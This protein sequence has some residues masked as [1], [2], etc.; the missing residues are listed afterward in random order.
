MRE[1]DFLMF[2][3][4]GIGEDLLAAVLAEL[5][6]EAGITWQAYWDDFVSFCKQHKYYPKSKPSVFASFG[7]CAKTNFPSVSM[8]KGADTRMA[9]AWL[10]TLAIPDPMLD[11]AVFSLADYCYV[12]DR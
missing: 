12:M 5:A 7:S 1:D 4:A 2:S 8:E 3:H 6:D 9:I 11:L 10:A